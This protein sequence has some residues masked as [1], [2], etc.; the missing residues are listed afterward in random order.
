MLA[1][2]VVAGPA[3]GCVRRSCWQMQCARRD[4]VDCALGADAKGSIQM[5]CG[6]DSGMHPACGKPSSNAMRVDPVQ[7]F[8]Y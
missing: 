6:G 8:T 7:Y 5:L 2:M 4:C 1:L 3:V